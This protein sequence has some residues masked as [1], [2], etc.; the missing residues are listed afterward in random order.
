M[1]MKLDSCMSDTFP[2]YVPLPICA[3]PYMRHALHAPRPICPTP[4]ICAT[5][6]MRHTYA[7]PISLNLGLSSQSVGRKY[8]A[9]KPSMDTPVHF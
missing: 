9:P 3:T 8:P 2:P 7:R 4:Y 1:N 6:Y 5:P